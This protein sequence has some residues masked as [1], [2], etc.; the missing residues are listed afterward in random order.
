[1]RKKLLVVFMLECSCEGKSVVQPLVETII[2]S[3]EYVLVVINVFSNSV[4]SYTIILFYFVR[5]AQNFHTIIVQRV[6]FCK[7][8]HIEPDTLSW[9]GIGYPE[10]VPLGISIRVDI[11]LEY[12]II[13]IIRKFNGSK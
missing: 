12:K 7:I 5:E 4:P 13:F 10:K 11:I 9:L 1:M 8:Y 6:W 3:F 2:F